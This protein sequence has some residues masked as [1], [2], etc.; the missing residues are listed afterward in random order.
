M[1][2][3]Y[4]PAWTFLPFS[5]LAQSFLFVFFV[6]KTPLVFIHLNIYNL[7][8]EEVVHIYKVAVSNPLPS[9]S[10]IQ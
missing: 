2:N 7:I 1:F 5:V 4:A 10:K 3:P 8:S 9:I 6:S